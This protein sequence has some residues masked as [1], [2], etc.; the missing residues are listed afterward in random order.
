[1]D[2]SV[3]HPKRVFV[4]R[5]IE[6][7]VR[8]SYFDRVKGTIPPTMLDTGV[9]AEEA[10]SATYAY[11]SEGEH[12]PTSN[13]SASPLTRF[14]SQ[15][16]LTRQPP[17]LSWASFATREQLEKSTKSSYTSVTRCKKNTTSTRPRLSES[18]S[19]WPFRQS[20]KSAVVHSPTS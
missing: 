17:A 12:S 16:I 8:L 10:P 19:T 11:E 14:I 5:T 9:M 20:S 3:K 13:F 7:E 18:S 2:V 4:K 1:M 15:I 6:L